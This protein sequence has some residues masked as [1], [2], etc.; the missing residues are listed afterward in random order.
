MANQSNYC[1]DEMCSNV[2][3]TDLVCGVDEL[4]PFVGHGQ[5]DGWHFLHLFR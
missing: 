1:P 5:Y 2:S 4:D 3:E